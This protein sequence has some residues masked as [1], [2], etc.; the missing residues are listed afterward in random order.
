M[1]LRLA[2]VSAV[3]LFSLAGCDRADAPA[4]PSAKVET[5]APEAP[6]PAAHTDVVATTEAPAPPAAADEAPAFAVLYP[7]AQVDGAPLTAN[8]AAGPGGLVTFTTD[9]TPDQVVAFYRQ[10]AE[11]AGLKS[12]TGM[13]QG[14][15]RAYGAAGAAA[16]GPSLQIVA[17]PSPDGATSVHMNWSAGS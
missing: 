4:R 8:G 2:A 16:D 14:E 9:A 6:V 11:A 15:A 13:N 1:M 10:R 12:V 5:A 17:A 7:G 3:V